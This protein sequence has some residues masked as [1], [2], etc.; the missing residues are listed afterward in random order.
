[1]QMK[2]TVEMAGGGHKW[3]TEYSSFKSKKTQTYLRSGS[4]I[5]DS[6]MMKKSLGKARSKTKIGK[7]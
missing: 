3:T 4:L 7:K 6:Q 2:Y 5:M 1:M